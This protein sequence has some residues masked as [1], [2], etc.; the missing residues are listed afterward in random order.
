MNVAQ[1]NRLLVDRPQWS[2][3]HV[4]RMPL[5]KESDEELLERIRCHNES[6]LRELFVR[7]YARLAEFAF[8]LVRRRD[9][10]EEAVMNVFL[11]LWRRRESLVLS[12]ILRSYLFAAAGNQSLNLR[13][14]QLRHAA[15]GLDDVHPSQ[16]VGASRTE[17]DLLYRELHAEI[18]A[19]ITRLPPQRQLIFRMNRLQGLRYAEIAE[20]LGVSERTVQN[21]M[22][23]AV[24]QLSSELPQLR[25]TLQ[26]NGTRNPFE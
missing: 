11:N 9:L 16:L 8:S 21:H 26:R 2:A 12:G 13:K 7:Y 25:G 24:R 23:Q 22:V 18:D 14:R 17:G 19:M 4:S 20:A 1:G 10:A 6:A 15:V 3:M 5:R